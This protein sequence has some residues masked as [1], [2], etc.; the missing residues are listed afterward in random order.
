MTNLE[1]VDPED[2]PARSAGELR[3]PARVILAGVTVNFLL[4]F[5]LF[6][7]VIAGQG[8]ISEGPSTTISTGSWRTARRR[9]R[10]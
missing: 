1:E 5:V 4:A 7:V 3:R 10:A 6:F 8:R 9:T 2:E